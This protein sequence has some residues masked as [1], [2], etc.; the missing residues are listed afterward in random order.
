[1]DPRFSPDTAPY[2]VSSVHESEATSD[3]FIYIQ[4]ILYVISSK[5]WT[6]RLL[7]LPSLNVWNRL[8]FETFW[9]EL[10]QNDM[11]RPKNR[12]R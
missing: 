8:C 3:N 5:Y 10:K 2:E 6:L 1:M 9:P 7:H 11:D 4:T 12:A